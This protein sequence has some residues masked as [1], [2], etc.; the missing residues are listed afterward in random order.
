MEKK[1]L[2]LDA[3]A[4]LIIAHVPVKNFNFHSKA[5]Y[6]CIMIRRILEAVKD[7]SQIDDRDYLGNKRLEL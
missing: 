7:P 1:D 6:I 3:L 4:N 2:A 5:I